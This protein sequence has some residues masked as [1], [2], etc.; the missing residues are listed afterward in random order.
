MS[1]CNVAGEYIASAVGAV[2]LMN[3]G[4]VM[5]RKMLGIALL[6]TWAAAVSGCQS[7]WDCI[8][9]LGGGCHS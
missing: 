1:T 3:E 9:A 4:N 8:Q 6:L 2:R 7:L 5:V